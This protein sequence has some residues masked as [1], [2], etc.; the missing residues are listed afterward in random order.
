[1]K[2]QRGVVLIVSLIFL[3]ALTITAVAIMNN[4]TS[5]NRMAGA[6]EDRFIASQ[7]AISAVDQIIATQV[8]APTGQNSFAGNINVYPVNGVEGDLTPALAANTTAQITVA[9]QGASIGATCP[10]SPVPSSIGA[11]SCNMLTINVRR[12]YGRVNAQGNRTSNVVVV[13]GIVQEVRGNNN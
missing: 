7:Q 9:N 13:T 8:R 5:E 2:K 4:T 11:I 12:N 3:V 1:M 6:H 10:H